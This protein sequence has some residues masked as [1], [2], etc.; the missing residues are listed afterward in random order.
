MTEQAK[1]TAYERGLSDYK[2]GRHLNPF[3]PGSDEA[4]E[5]D[6]GQDAGHV[7]DECEADDA[8]AAI[9]KAEGR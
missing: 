9:A 7:L 2:A 5:Y 4:D 8:R 1:H 3:T 6:T